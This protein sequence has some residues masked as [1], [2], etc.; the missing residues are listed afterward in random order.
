[1]NRTDAEKSEKIKNIYKI[2]DRLIDLQQKILEVEENNYKV[3]NEI[4][5]EIKKM[6]QRVDNLLKVTL[7]DYVV[8]F[9]LSSNITYHKEEESL[10]Y[11][12]KEKI[13]NFITRMN[14]ENVSIKDAID[15]I[16]YNILKVGD[17]AYQNANDLT[18]DWTGNGL[19]D[20]GHNTVLLNTSTT[21]TMV[22]DLATLIDADDGLSS[23]NKYL[24]STKSADEQLTQ[25]YVDYV[26]Y[27]LIV[28]NLLQAVEII[29][30]KIKSFNDLKINHY[31]TFYDSLKDILNKLK[32]PRYYR[33]FYK[34]SNKQGIFESDISNFKNRDYVEIT[35][36]FYEIN[37]SN[38]EEGEDDKDDDD[39]NGGSS[40]NLFEVSRI[41]A[42]YLVRKGLNSLLKNYSK[43]KLKNRNT[44]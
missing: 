10:S 40:N 18:I 4:L 7:S 44:N 9:P 21:T 20:N 22:G 2:E 38:T 29:L 35:A 23:S 16:R 19:D 36:D 11:M 17:M 39:G 6:N 1:M 24:L 3:N 28:K 34:D 27:E 8:N 41:R 37:K 31:F 33:I 13:S 25:I 26:S 32:I 42:A 14:P 5:T 43:L 15:Y 12:Y 30:N